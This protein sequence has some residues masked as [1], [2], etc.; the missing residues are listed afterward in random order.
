MTGVRAHPFLRRGIFFAH[1][2]MAEVLDAHE[3]G[4]GFY[5]YTGRVRTRLPQ[6]LPAHLG[7]CVATALQSLVHAHAGFCATTAEQRSYLC[8]GGLDSKPIVVLLDGDSCALSH[9][10]RRGLSSARNRAR[11]P[12]NTAVCT[13][14]VTVCGCIPHGVPL[15]MRAAGSVVG[16]AAPGAPDPLHVHQVAPGRLQGAA[17]RPAHRRREVP[18]EVCSLIKHPSS[19]PSIGAPLAACN[20]GFGL[21]KRMFCIA[22]R[23][24]LLFC[25]ASFAGFLS[26]TGHRKVPIWCT[27]RAV[28][29]LLASPPAR[30]SDSI[31]ALRQGP[32]GRRGAAAGAGE[33]EGHHRLRLRRR[34]DVHLQRLRL[35]R[36]RHVPQHSQ[37]TEVLSKLSL[38]PHQASAKL[39]VHHLL[40]IL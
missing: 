3:K 36:R 7:N 25:T 14:G 10:P 24:S 18:L 39:L 2:D 4:Q 9:M 38:E 1:R 20:Q 21:T 6:G 31:R 26:S 16:C 27:N 32:G 35:R 22:S 12:S 15:L 13:D 5:L 37:D 30:A 28:L 11:C 34:P 23:S 33:R 29:H 19:A 8:I 17:G 40:C